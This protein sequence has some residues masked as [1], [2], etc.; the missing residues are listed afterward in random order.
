MLFEKLIEQHCIDY[1]VVHTL[2]LT[3]GVLECGIS[4]RVVSTSAGVV[5][6]RQGANSIIVVAGLVV[7][8]RGRTYRCVGKPGGVAEECLISIRCVV[9]TGVGKER[10]NASGRI[11]GASRVKKQRSGA[12]GGIETTGRIKVQRRTTDSRIAAAGGVTEKRSGAYRCILVC[13]VHEERPSADAC[14]EL[15]VREAQK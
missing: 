12:D 1:F 8:E 4:H 15:A 11:V 14:V 13:G 6:E 7:C 2:R 5:Q 3:V 9:I 10:L